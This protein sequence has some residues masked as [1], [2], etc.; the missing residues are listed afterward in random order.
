MG[1]NKKKIYISESKVIHW[2]IRNDFQ[3]NLYSVKIKKWR[4]VTKDVL[5]KKKYFYNFSSDFSNFIQ[6]FSFL[7]ILLYLS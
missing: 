1:K 5:K 7:G 2:V 6:I 3:T 4:P